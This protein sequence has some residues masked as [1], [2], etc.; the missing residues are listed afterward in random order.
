MHVLDF[1]FIDRVAHARVDPLLYGTPPDCV[2]RC[3]AGILARRMP[4]PR[5]CS[6]ERQ[7]LWRRDWIECGAD[8]ARMGHRGPI[9]ARCKAL[10]YSWAVAMWTLTFRSRVCTT[11]RAVAF[12]GVASDRRHIARFGERRARGRRPRGLWAGLGAT[13]ARR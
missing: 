7:T 3:A 11:K 2:T 13:R 8:R 6:K 5:I 4:R 9:R 1:I 12:I 10:Q